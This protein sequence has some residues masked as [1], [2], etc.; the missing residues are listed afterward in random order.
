MAQ[1]HKKNLIYFFNLLFAIQLFPQPGEKFVFF[2]DVTQ[3]QHNYTENYLEISYSYRE[4]NLTYLKNGNIY[5]STV[6]M[7]VILS[8]EKK[9]SVYYNQVFNI[10]HLVDDTTTFS[11]N[12]Y[13]GKINIFIPNMDQIITIKSI[14]EKNQSR[15]DTVVYNLNAINFDTS[16]TAISDVELASTI[17]LAKTEKRNSFLKNSLE[18]IP[19]P[20]RIYSSNSPRLY[21]YVEAYNLLSD[22]NSVEYMTKAS[23]INLNGIELLSREN[24]KKRLNNSSVEVGYLDISTL[25]SGIYVFVFT[26][27]NPSANLG[28]NSS[29]SFTFVNSEKPNPSSVTLSSSELLESLLYSKSI[30]EL[31][32]EFSSLTYIITRS[33]KKAY[34]KLSSLDEKVKFL[35]EFWDKRDSDLQTPLNEGREEYLSRVEYASRFDIG[36]KKGWQTDRGRIIITYGE[37]DEYVREFGDINTIPH[38]TWYY[39]NIQGGVSFVFAATGGG[40]EY[41]LI[42]STHRNELQNHNWLDLITR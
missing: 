20:S 30:N 22:K 40:Q 27:I 15:I 35:A 32:N 41:R 5:E 1:D 13:V 18:V 39:N 9:D 34:N 26:L 17:K 8:S 19:N 12:S 11:E 25:S 2:T 23:I 42:H 16:Q 3:F 21:Y 33:E 37:A 29:K 31:D 4:S 10:P 14:D 38:E 28:I 6:L 36:M 24:S 7:N